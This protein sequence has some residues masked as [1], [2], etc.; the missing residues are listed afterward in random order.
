MNEHGKSDGPIVPQT[1]ANNGGGNR[2]DMSHPAASPAE[3]VEGR[4]P[5]KGNLL[6]GSEDRTQNRKS[7]Q[8]ALERIRKVGVTPGRHDPRQEPGAVIPHAGICPGGAPQGAF[9]PE[10]SPNSNVGVTIIFEMAYAASQ[11]RDASAAQWHRHPRDSGV[12]WPVIQSAATRICR[13]A[14]KQFVPGLSL[15]GRCRMIAAQGYHTGNA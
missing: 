2:F 8:V 6:R 14:G 13:N 4:G 1:P 7:L 12:T 15:V 10:S 3:Q 5:A 11:L 9:L